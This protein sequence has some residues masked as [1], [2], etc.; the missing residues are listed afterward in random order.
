MFSRKTAW[1]RTIVN[2]E[3]ESIYKVLVYESVSNTFTSFP[4]CIF[5]CLYLCTYV[6]I[7]V[8]VYW[9]VWACKYMI[10][11][12]D[13]TCTLITNQANTRAN[14]NKYMHE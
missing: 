3:Q 11:G 7:Y 14:R 6:C 9:R 12:G 5:V 1:N 4:V 13:M 8:C 10:V 2:N